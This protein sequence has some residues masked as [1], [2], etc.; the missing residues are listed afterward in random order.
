MS[1]YTVD[2]N[3][4]AVVYRLGKYHTT[5]GPGLHFKLPLL[6]KVEHAKV[7]LL[8]KKEFGYET[9]DAG[10][11]TQYSPVAQENISLMI[12]ND[13][14]I[15]EVTWVVQY[16]IGNAYEYLVNVKNVEKA[17]LDLSEAGMRLQIGD[18][19]FNDILSNRGDLG[20][21]SGVKDYMQRFLDLYK[22]G[23]SIG[24]VKLQTAKYPEQN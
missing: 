5:V 19:S 9:T 22:S 3:E 21:E 24:S 4:D 2:A 14:S 1:Y 18:V 7:G 8:H 10:V 20:I 16:R 11:K 15:V 17:I 12:T 6:D 23:I 13:P